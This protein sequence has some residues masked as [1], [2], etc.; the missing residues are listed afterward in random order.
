M[1]KVTVIMPSLNV[2]KYIKPCMESVLAQTF[3]DIEILAID[4]GSDDGTLEILQKYALLDKRVKLIHS[5]K[6]SYGYQLNLGISLAQ[7]EYIGVVETDDIIVADMFETLYHQAIQTGVDY[8]KGTA[9]TFLKSASG[10]EVTNR[11]LCV[12]NGED[13]GKI[14]CP[15]ENPELFV[16]DRFLWL[17]IYKSSFLRSVKLNETKG[18]AFQDIGFAFQVIEK[19]DKAVYLNKDVY[20]YRQ[21]NVNASSHDAKS[22]QYLVAEYTYIMQFLKGKSDRWYQAYYH[23]MWNQC[24]G[25]FLKM[26]AL[27]RFWEEAYPEISQLQSWIKEAVQKELLTEHMVG[28]AN[29]K[30]VQLFLIDLQGIYEECRMYYQQKKKELQDI[31]QV[32]EKQKAIIFGVGRYGKFTHALLESRLPGRVVA[33]CDNNISLRNQEVQGIPVLLPEDAVGSHM[34]AVYIV[35]NRRYEDEIRQQL[36]TLGVPEESVY[37]YEAGADLQLFQL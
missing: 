10:I 29:W 6:K 4:A 9:Q 26:A 2:A 13:M 14:I 11:I 20:Y 18:A 12:S 17:G 7:G 37:R 31:L 23:K 24:L 25:R 32:I 22:F 33:F 8:V 36:K 30:K 1:P 3:K 35:T 21:D 15:K 19:A 27:G 34:D 5:N 28:V 16:T